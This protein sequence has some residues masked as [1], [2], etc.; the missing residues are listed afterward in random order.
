MQIWAACRDYAPDPKKA[1][2]AFWGAQLRFFRQLVCF[3]PLHFVLVVME[4]RHF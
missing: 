3:W 2:T 4:V 1:M